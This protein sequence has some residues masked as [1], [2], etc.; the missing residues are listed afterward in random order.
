[1]QVNVLTH[2]AT[3]TLD[4][5]HF[6][7]INVLKKLHNAQ[8]QKELYVDNTKDATS[9]QVV[10]SKKQEGHK[11]LVINQN[12]IYWRRK[13]VKELSLTLIK[14]IRG[15][16]RVQIKELRDQMDINERK[17]SAR[18]MWY[19][20]IVK[21]VITRMILQVLVW[22]DLIWEMEVLCWTYLGGKILLNSKNISKNISES[23]D[24]PSVFH[25]S[26]Y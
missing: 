25:C 10:G 22:L 7:R 5:E 4:S 1:M 18:N 17:R 9:E 19:L 26:R 15:R 3:V 11:L 13:A 14:N 8:D 6:K 21:K 20:L 23:L 16:E 24:I 12:H 2:T